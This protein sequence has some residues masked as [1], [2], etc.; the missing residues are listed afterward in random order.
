MGT[1]HQACSTDWSAGPPSR[2]SE[3]PCPAAGRLLLALHPVLPSKQDGKVRPPPPQPHGEPGLEPGEGTQRFFHIPSGKQMWEISWNVTSK[4]GHRGMVSLGLA[5]PADTWLSRVR[6]PGP[7]AE[8]VTVCALELLSK[9]T[10]YAAMDCCCSHY[11]LCSLSE[12]DL[13]VQLFRW[14]L[15]LDLTLGITLRTMVNPCPAM[16]VVLQSSG[17]R[18]KKAVR[19]PVAGGT[20]ARAGGCWRSHWGVWSRGTGQ[21]LPVASLLPSAVWQAW[22]AAS[23]RESLKACRVGWRTSLLWALLGHRRGG[24]GG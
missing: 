21:W 2:L 6:I 5:A 8:T 3:S 9:A 7:E 15:I 24:P 13:R 4:S 18:T 20:R 22:I 16:A 19:A 10:C 11:Y 1:A 23:C 14:T 17:Q 12:C